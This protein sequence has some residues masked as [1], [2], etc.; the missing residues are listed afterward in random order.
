M[1]PDPETSAGL[2]P[3][4]KEKRDAS[5]RRYLEANER[6]VRAA[7]GPPPFPYAE[8]KRLGADREK[9]LEQYYESLPRMA[10]SRCPLCN[11]ALYRV[12]DPWG[13]DGFW[14]QEKLGRAARELPACS[15]FRV[16]TGALNLNGLPTV[17]GREEAFPGPEVPYVVPRLL[18]LP[19]MIAV[20]SSIRMP[21]GYTAYPVTYFSNQTPKPGTLTQTWT[22]RSYNYQDAKGQPKFMYDTSPWDFD[23]LSW[24]DRGRLVWIDRNDTGL[25]IK[26][27]PARGCP[28]PEDAP[29][30]PNVRS[31][32]ALSW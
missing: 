32:P 19:A 2:G 9:A 29:D 7:A 24:I 4:A 8:R 13:L 12:F 10:I 6:F 20:V 23:L 5:M 11:K 16:L 15:H 3:E 26:R 25:D 17:G 30:G 14:W 27:A 21:N 22:Q 18:G 31:Y 28:Y 1:A